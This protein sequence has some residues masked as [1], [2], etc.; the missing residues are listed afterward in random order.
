MYQDRKFKINA[1]LKTHFTI[2]GCLKVSLLL[3]LRFAIV[4]VVVDLLSVTLFNVLFLRFICRLWPDHAS[5]HNNLGTLV[6]DP[7]VAK[8]HF[9]E[10]I[11][12]NPVHARAHFNM[13]NLLRYLTFLLARSVCFFCSTI[14]ACK[15]RSQRSNTR[16]QTITHRQLVH[17]QHGVFVVVAKQFATV[18]HSVLPMNS[19]S[20]ASSVC[21]CKDVFQRVV[22][23]RS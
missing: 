22:R 11:R 7:L 5:A 23:L 8:F 13:G 18:V 20:T 3:Q 4:V 19:H 9:M 15:G 6:D 2:Y 1:P 21:S 14:H 17:S 10:A 16:V 12:I